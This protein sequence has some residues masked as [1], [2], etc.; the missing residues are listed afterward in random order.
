VGRHVD[1]AAPQRDQAARER[2]GVGAGDGSSK[3]GRRADAQRGEF[4]SSSERAADDECDRSSRNGP[5]DRAQ[6]AADADQAS[7]GAGLPH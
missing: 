3:R 1:V 6:P 7:L 5:D 2:R 4:G